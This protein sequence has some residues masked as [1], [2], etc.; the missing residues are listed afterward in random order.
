MLVGL[1]GCSQPSDLPEIPVQYL[2]GTS[3][4]IS[5]IEGKT[6]LV[7]YQPGCD[8][9]QR[10]ASTLEQNLQSF[11]EYEVYFIS[12]APVYEN[13]Q[14]ATEYKLINQPNIHFGTTLGDYIIKNFGSI[15]TPSFYIYSSDGKLIKEFIGE[16]PIEEILAQI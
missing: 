8:H 2:D 5:G 7:L 16:T 10:A 11:K 3:Q 6:M 9:C 13:K 14:F 4:D 1:L 12:S 15:P